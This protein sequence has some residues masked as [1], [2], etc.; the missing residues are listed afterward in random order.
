M[1][2]AL[3]ALAVAQFAR[4]HDWQ[5]AAVAGVLLGLGGATKLSPLAVAAGLSGLALVLAVFSPGCVA[6]G[7]ARRKLARNGLLIGLAASVTFVAVYPYLWLDPI[8][9]SMNLFTFRVVEMATQASDW[10][11]MAV[12]NR[13]D[14]LRRMGV[15]FSEHYSLLGAMAEA[16]HLR[17]PRSLLQVEVLLAVAGI[18]VM[19]RN[20][21]RAGWL[22]AQTL[23][24]AVLG[25]QVIVTILGMRAEF[26]RYHLPAALL[27]AVALCVS[28]HAIATAMRRAMG[29]WRAQQDAPVRER[30][31]VRG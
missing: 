16:V 6:E 8:G 24:L 30:M 10:P 25:G 23:V 26:D 12:P 28:V 3:A 17:A 22:S 2:I 14:A 29:G 18:G 1:L 21:L 31:V 11:V 7:E 9:R 19:A 15:N 4:K 27:G 5:W 13:L 20:A